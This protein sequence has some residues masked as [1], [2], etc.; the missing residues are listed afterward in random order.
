MVLI[1]TK[2]CSYKHICARLGIKGHM[3]TF[4]TKFDYIHYAITKIILLN[5]FFLEPSFGRIDCFISLPIDVNT[6]FCK[7]KSTILA[8]SAR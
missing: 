4:V 2:G 3:T 6:H 1:K 7:K 5:L 8:P